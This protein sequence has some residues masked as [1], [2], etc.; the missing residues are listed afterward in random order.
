[1]A[2]DFTEVVLYADVLFIIDF[3]MDFISLYF[4]GKLNHISM[5]TLRLCAA[6]LFSA[7]YSLIITI[8]SLGSLAGLFLSVVCS[9]IMCLVAFGKASKYVIIRRT[10]ILW[11]SGSLIGGIMTAVTSVGGAYNFNTSRNAASPLIYA[12]L[13]VCVFIG[14]IMIHII[15]RVSRKSCADVTVKLNDCQVTF[16][17]LA[18]SGNLLTDPFTGTPV[19]IVSLE[20]LKDVL[21][22]EEYDFFNRA[23]GETI[24]PSS[25]NKRL[26]LIPSKS[27]HGERMLYALRTDG[28]L[29]ENQKKNAVLAVENVKSGEY[30]SFDGIVPSALI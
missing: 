28:I 2:G 5:K 27:I 8:L 1:M 7:S 17:A 4:T 6:A 9:L 25:L 23:G 20:I 12:V 22:D 26:R 15:G 21:D 11:A 16:K 29:V 30:G 19:I 18:D 3:S 14:F 24:M 10:V 13:A